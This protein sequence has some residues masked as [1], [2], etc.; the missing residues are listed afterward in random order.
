MYVVCNLAVSIVIYSAVFSFCLYR[1]GLPHVMYCRL[2]RWPDL[3]TH[4]ELKA[5]DTCQYAFSSKK[6][7]VCVNPYHYIRIE[8]PSQFIISSFYL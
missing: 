1:K 4:H 8:S 7:E 6:D 3:Q 2:W 5:I